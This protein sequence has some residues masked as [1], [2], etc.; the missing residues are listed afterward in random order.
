MCELNLPPFGILESWSMG[1]YGLVFLV[2]VILAY[3][4]ISCAQG[5]PEMVK[6]SVV[7]RRGFSLNRTS[8]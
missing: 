8:E 6:P 4:L 3:K 5:R 2:V 7:V 1:V